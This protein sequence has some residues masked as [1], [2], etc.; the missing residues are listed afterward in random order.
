MEIGRGKTG[1]FELRDHLFNGWGR[2]SNEGSYIEDKVGDRT[3]KGEKKK[4]KKK[5]KNHSS[6]CIIFKKTVFSSQH[7][8][9]K[10]KG[11]TVRG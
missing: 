2:G 11:R 10:T 9:T 1:N 8:V 3:T 5:K 6:G 7:T 4:R